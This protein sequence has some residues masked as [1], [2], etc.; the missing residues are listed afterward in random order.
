M[1]HIRPQILCETSNSAKGEI[2]MFAKFIRFF[3]ALAVIVSIVG[4][5]GVARAVHGTSPG[6][7]A[8]N[9]EA[10]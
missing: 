6:V 7:N 3:A 10:S 2:K 9:L 8:Q 5:A 1:G 4:N